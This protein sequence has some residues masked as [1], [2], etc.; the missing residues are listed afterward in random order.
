MNQSTHYQ[1]QILLPRVQVGEYLHT[2]FT[3]NFPQ[4]SLAYLSY[5][6][7]VHPCS[8]AEDSHCSFFIPVL[9]APAWCPT[10]SGITRYGEQGGNVGLFIPQVSVV[11]IDI[12]KGRRLR[13]L[14]KAAGLT[15]SHLWRHGKELR[16]FSSRSKVSP[17]SV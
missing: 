13:K 3:Y 7:K 12:S 15:L 11:C 16:S 17:P 14:R 6:W 8:F 2:N 4:K 5:A 9:S 1:T 10:K